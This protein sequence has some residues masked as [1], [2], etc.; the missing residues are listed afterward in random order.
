MR[1]TVAVSKSQ[2]CREIRGARSRTKLGPWE[3]ER[4]KNRLKKV[5][6]FISKYILD[7]YL[8]VAAL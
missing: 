2:S 7:S 4:E 1:T 8:S 5:D 3:W 6:I